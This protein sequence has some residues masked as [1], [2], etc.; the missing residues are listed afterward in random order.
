MKRSV[1]LMVSLVT[2]LSLLMSSCAPAAPQE[3]AK[4][5]KLAV[6]LPGVITDADYN[7]LAYIALTGVKE[8]MGIETAYSES[9]PVPDVER[10]MREYVDNGFNVIW[11]HGGQF[12]TQTQKLATEFKDV[13]F[14][15][16]G[17]APVENMPENMWMIDR[18]F[19][20]GY[21][22]IGALAA[23]A[24]KTG[25]IGYIAGQTLPFSYAEVHAMQQ[26]LK[27]Q[28][29]NV[30]L[31]TVWSGD[32]NDPT[33]GRQVADAMMADGIDVLVCSLNLGVMGV[34]EAVKAQPGK[35]LVT[36]KYI[37]KAQ[38][39]PE[40]YITALLYD[41]KG[42]LK[43]MITK[44]QAGEK[45][46]YYPLGFQTGV[47]LQTPLTNVSPEVGEYVEKIVDDIKSGKIEVVKDITPIK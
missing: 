20:I 14:I 8:E 11:T 40:A 18:N 2:L 6:V 31:K 43:E 32:F 36:A 13:T 24:S 17:D 5:I 39:A 23:K 10:V 42:P 1:L 19:H 37:D 46:A 21:Y 35:A 7:S 12:I 27:D 16:E 4:K 33:K 30:E 34:F 22:A 44:I 3:T 45:G 41:F 25:K 29:L 28:N 38:Y 9:V 26:A 15:G 47:A